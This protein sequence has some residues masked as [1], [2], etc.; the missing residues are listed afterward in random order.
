M[1]QRLGDCL[2]EDPGEIALSVKMPFTCG[3]TERPRG[4]LLQLDIDVRDLLL[5]IGGRL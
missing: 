4:A 1:G 3:K 2:N 5:S